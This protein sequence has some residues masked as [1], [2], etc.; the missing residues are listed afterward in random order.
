M[1][2][3]SGL[4]ASFLYLETHAQ[5]MHVCGVIVL[6]PGT[7][8]G[9]YSFARTQA[10]I[11]ARVRDVPAF[12]RRLR[13]VPLDLDHP[14]WVRDRR[15]DIERHVHRLA[16]PAPGGYRELM[17]LTSH[18]AGLPLDRSR[19]LWEMWVIEGYAAGGADRVVVFSKMHHA[20]VDGVSGANLVSHLCSLEPDA[21]PLRLEEPGTFGGDPGQ[22]ALLG[23]GV[24]SNLTRP[25]NAVRLLAPSATMVTR[26]IERARAGTA[27][28][29]PLTAPRT[30][31]NGTITGRRTIALADLDLED[32]R[33]VKRATGVTVNDVVL[34]VAGGALRGYLAD[35]DELPDD[36]LLA[37]V[38][39]SVHSSSRHARGAN[40]VSALFTRLGTDEEDLAR[41]ACALAER[42]RHARST[43]TRSAPTPC[44]TGRSSPRPGPSGWPCAY[45]NLRLAERHPV[46]HNLVI[47]NVPGPPV[48]LYFTGAWIEA[49]H[50]LGPVFHGAGLNI[51]VMSNDGKRTS[52]SSPAAS[53]CP[54]PTT[55]SAGS[56]SSLTRLKE[57]AT[58]P[59]ARPV[60][61]SA[62]FAVCRRRIDG[63]LSAVRRPLT[64]PSISPRHTANAAENVTGRQV[65][66]A[67]TVIAR[68]DEKN[69][70]GTNFSASRTQE[71]V[72]RRRRGRVAPGMARARASW[73]EGGMT[74]SRRSHDDGGAGRRCG[75]ARGGSGGGRG[76]RGPG[77]RPTG[78]C[79]GTRAWPTRG[80]RSAPATGRER[81]SGWRG[82]PYATG[83]RR[84][85]RA[86]WRPSRRRT[87]ARRRSAGTG[88]S[89]RRAPAPAPD[90]VLAPDAL[91]DHAAHR[92]ARDHR[93][94]PRS[95]AS[96][97]AATSSAQSRSE[98]SALRIPWP[99]QRWSRVTTRKRRDSG[100]IAGYQVSRPV[101]PRACSSTTVGESGVG[102][103]VS[104]TYVVPRP[105]S[106]TGAA[107]RDPRPRQVDPASRPPG[108]G[109][110][111]G[112]SHRSTSHLGMPFQGRTRYSSRRGATPGTQRRRSVSSDGFV[113]ADADAAEALD[114]VRSVIREAL[115]RSADWPALAAA[116][117]LGLPVPTAYGG[118]GARSPRGGRPGSG[119]PPLARCTC[120]S[121]RRCAA[122]CSPWPRTAPEQQQAEPAPR[123][124]HRRDRAVAGSARGGCGDHGHAVDDVPRRDGERPQDRRVV[125]R[126]RGPAA[127]DGDP[128]RPAGGRAGRPERPRRRPALVHRL[129]PRASTPSSS[130]R[131]RPSCSAT[132]RTGCSATWPSPG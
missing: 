79:C 102:P 10:S 56:P 78:W 5:L 21:E 37:T 127:R 106:S 119:R 6:D 52:A 77:R 74:R 118:E 47:S 22:L 45:A 100:S 53:P 49:L 116:G 69:R 4:D 62:L 44:R 93:G 8:P 17:E 122:A 39:V 36:S 87:P 15:F 46:V 13:R 96:S 70:P 124:R 126:G 41:A 92:V 132:A 34:A 85:P 16:P 88:R 82:P 114:A 107:C 25:L 64:D 101:Q 35:R 51:T 75:P 24:V 60:T 103:G 80:C 1:D 97:N 27:M 42:N 57:A 108:D 54:T 65:L 55:W 28:S 115:D 72:R 66:R 33:A 71:G 31:F 129:Q 113:Q 121:G 11:E 9:G 30:S 18:L 83:T 63:S 48:P 3:L 67:R 81:R 91:R 14:V 117:V 105:A 90:R 29:A 58:R 19:P 61:F 98:N 76:R 32:V 104:V 94:S 84:G 23:R 123:R 73:R 26:T 112:A 99:C 95:S 89:S 40:K 131:R 109:R 120:P 20:T 38:P 59:R 43:T 130:T 111:H 68:L 12:T 86:S 2:R 128:R 110:G 125:R 50:A 7:V